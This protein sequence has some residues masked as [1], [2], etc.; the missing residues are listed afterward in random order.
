[1]AGPLTGLKVLDFSTLLPGPY[2][3]MILADLGADVLRVSSG[4]RLDLVELFPPFLPGTKHSAIV[5]WLG[6]GKRTMTLNLK[7]KQALEIVH[8][9]IKEYDI[10]L[11]QFRPGVMGKFGLGYSDVKKINPAIIYCSLTGYGQ[12]GP[13][14]MNAGHDI[15]YIARSGLMDFSGR[16]ESGPSLTG[17]QIADVAAGSNN[18]VIGILSAVI[19]RNNTGKGQYVDI[20]MLDGVMAFNTIAGAGFLGGEKEPK[21]ETGLING[22]SLYDFYETKDG[23][24]ISFGGLEP[25][26]FKAFCETIGCEDLIPQGVTPKNFSAEKERVRNILKSKTRDEWVKEFENVDACIEPVLSLGEAAKDSQTIEREMVVELECPDG[27]SIKQFAT[28]ITFSE[29]K[30]QYNKIGDPTGT[31]TKEV[32]AELGYSDSEYEEFK[33]N[34]VFN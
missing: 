3:S 34:D 13:V 33:K 32:M 23:K 25:Q 6:R 8:K 1:M 15:N 17:M 2:A 18:A 11:E 14:S 16:K 7:D 30:P 4:S 9:L 26:F 12:T 20:S 22:G 10:V 31:H 19:N 28:P 27:T 21:R 5:A 29:T 24:H